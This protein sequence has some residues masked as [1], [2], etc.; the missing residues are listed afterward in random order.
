MVRILVVGLAGSR[1][2]ESGVSSRYES[3][4]SKDELP[5]V[6]SL[7]RRHF[8]IKPDSWWVSS[9]N[10]VI[11]PRVGKKRQVSVVIAGGN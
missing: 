2:E 11:A 7:C 3:Q 5:V 1:S 4:V 8:H 10:A 9:N 6:H